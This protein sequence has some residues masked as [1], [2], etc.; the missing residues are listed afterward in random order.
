MKLMHSV[1]EV[2]FFQYFLGIALLRGYQWSPWVPITIVSLSVAVFK[3]SL[4]HVWF[5]DVDEMLLTVAQAGVFVGGGCCFLMW[6][7]KS[8]V[9]PLLAHLSL[10]FIPLLRGLA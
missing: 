8:F 2:V 9:P 5:L 7:S 6:K 3:V 1:G 10:T 4:L